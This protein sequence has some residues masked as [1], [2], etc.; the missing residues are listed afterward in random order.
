M[1][2]SQLA[3]P[4][5]AEEP[6]DGSLPAI[7]IRAQE[8]AR[9]RQALARLGYAR[10]RSEYVRHKR[11]RK[12]TFA[13]LAQESLWPTTDFVHDWLKVAGRSII[14]RARGPCLMA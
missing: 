3:I 5:Q 10:V 1:L 4:Q 8:D 12:E 14:T 13:S 9:C 6:A 7:V 2:D 11:N